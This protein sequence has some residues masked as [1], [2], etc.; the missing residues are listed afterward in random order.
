VASARN[1]AAKMAQGSV[2]LF[3]DDDML[4]SKENIETTLTL[5]EKYRNSF[6]NLNWTYPPELIEK[7][8]QF[9]F[10]RFLIHYGFTSLKGWNGNSNWNNNELFKVHGI[11]SQYLSCKREDFYASGGY[12]EGFPFAGYEDSAFSETVN[13]KGFN[14]FIYPLSTLYHNETDRV[15]IKPWMARKTRGGVTVRTAFELGYKAQVH[16]YSWFKKIAY[17]SLI[18]MKPLLYG[19][20]KAL[21]NRKIFDF[22]SHRIIKL[23]LGIHIFDGYMNYQKHLK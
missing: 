2:L 12:N 5:H 21:P 22:F 9:S 20:Y 4:I 7:I 13:N 14:I 19:I 17:S 23:L 8:K 6:I 16:Q 10:G 1:Y 18:P 15:D 11:T 3:L